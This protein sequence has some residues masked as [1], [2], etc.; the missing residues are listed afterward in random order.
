MVIR[1]VVMGNKGRSIGGQASAH[2]AAYN[3]HLDTLKL[4]TAEGAR[5]NVAD[6]SGLNPLATAICT[7]KTPV[8]LFLASIS[9]VC[10]YKYVCSPLVFAATYAAFD[11][12]VGLL[13]IG[14]DVNESVA[15]LGGTALDSSVSQGNNRSTRVLLEAG[16]DTEMLSADKR[17]ALQTL[18]WNSSTNL[19]LI[20]DLLDCGADYAKL[21]HPFPFVS[22]A[23][24]ASLQAEGINFRK[25]K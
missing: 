8:A 14:L 6:A 16:A 1:R 9:T 4:L 21:P 17:T 25:S 3:G 24:R 20:Q 13:D 15:F 18:V 2:I 23:D 22:K 19:E 7:K 11:V 12:L 10:T 5:L